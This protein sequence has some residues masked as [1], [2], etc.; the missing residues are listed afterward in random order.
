MGD[1]D[2]V[3]LNASVDIR[4]LAGPHTVLHKHAVGEL[5]GPCPKC[6]G[7]DRLHVRRD[8]WYCNQCYTFDNG[9]PH[10]AVA[11]VMWLDG[12][13]FREAC[14][15]LGTPATSAATPPVRREP[16]PVVKAWR[17]PDWQR[18]QGEFVTRAADRLEMLAGAPS[19]AYLGGRGLR[20]ETWRRW[21]LGFVA[22]QRRGWPAARPAVV[23]PWRLGGHLIAVKLRF[24][25][26]G[27]QRY[28]S[29][30]GGEQALYGLDLCGQ[31]RRTLLLCEGEFNAMS[32]WQT[33]GDLG[34]ADRVDVVSF[35]SASGTGSKTTQTLA[36]AYER[37]FIW[38]DKADDAADLVRVLAGRG[39]A[40]QSPVRVGI[41]YDASAL[42]QTG[43][44][45]EVLGR[46]LDVGTTPAEPWSIVTL[47]LQDGS[48]LPVPAGRWARRADGLIEATYTRAELETALLVGRAGRT[49]AAA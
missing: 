5:A 37:V 48:G 9:R 43:R 40:L 21:G 12:V 24:V 3:R 17:Q 23:I 15:R 28:D 35:G 29:V 45:G 44:L 39:R 14:A 8:W 41:K 34:L 30:A 27:Q 26:D 16:A 2:T 10:D 7:T 4:D 20:P 36:R 22:W 42:L 11:F 33:V 47:V 31:H 1:I 6:G 18:K 25:D 46:V 32:L 19:R 49:G 13:D 38:T